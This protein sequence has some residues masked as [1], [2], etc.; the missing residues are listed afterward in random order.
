MPTSY[1]DMMLLKVFGRKSPFL[2]LSIAM[3]SIEFYFVVFLF[4]FT[5]RVLFDFDYKQAKS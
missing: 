4:W 2:C 5:D 1:I 3:L